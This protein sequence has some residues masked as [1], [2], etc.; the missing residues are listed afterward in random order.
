MRVFNNI[1]LLLF[2]STVTM[3]Q[4]REREV[5]GT[6]GHA[7]TTSDIQIEYTVGEA[8]VTSIDN[9]ELLLTQ[10]FH[11][12]RLVALPSGINFP[13]LVMYPNPTAGNT[14]IEF[15]LEAPARLQVVVTN[16]LGQL[17]YSEKISYSSGQMQYILRSL[18]FTA[19]AYMV[20]ISNL[21]NNAI[22]TKKLVKVGK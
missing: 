5:V 4:S 21:D 3:A 13:Y 2:C 14:Y 17:I 12:P 19:G 16:T 11:Q 10:G 7:A 8:V 15:S 18:T 22:I 9:G 6:T 1:I 20:T